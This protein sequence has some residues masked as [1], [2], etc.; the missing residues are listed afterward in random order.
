M[1]EKKIYFDQHK[2]ARGMAKVGWLTLYLLVTIFI[3]AILTLA[4]SKVPDASA[5]VLMFKKPGDWV[6]IG[7]VAASWILGAA[8]LTGYARHPQ[9]GWWFWLGNLAAFSISG[10]IPFLA[11]EMAMKSSLSV[12][13]VKRAVGITSASYWTMYVWLVLMAGMMVLINWHWLKKNN[14][15]WFVTLAPY[16]VYGL[17]VYRSQL[18]WYDFLQFDGFS[19][20]V[21]YRLFQSYNAVGFGHG[22]ALSMMNG[23]VTIAGTVM[24]IGMILMIYLGGEWLVFKAQDKI[25][26]KEAREEENQKA[27]QNG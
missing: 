17:F 8:F 26:A 22:A 3:T 7:I 4:I 16:L 10:A 20:R 23:T 27:G 18:A 19:Y 24:A 9:N 21:L 15:Y 12:Q 5:N 11:V 6:I 2:F 13:T 25:K 14:W 1:T